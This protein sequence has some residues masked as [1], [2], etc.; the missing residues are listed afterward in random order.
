MATRIQVRRGDASEWTS[1]D[2]VL[3]EGELGY[4]TDTGKFKIGNG[5]DL[6]S[7]LDY[8]L[9]SSDLSG[10]LTSS[11]ASTI[12]LTQ[13]SAS[14]TYL[15]QDSASTT[16]LTQQSA[17]ANYLTQE[18]ASSTYSPIVPTTQTGFRN[19]I[20]NGDFR[21][22][23]RNNGALKNNS[24]PNTALATTF[25]ADRWLVSERN[26][27]TGF[28]QRASDGTGADKYYLSISSPSSLNA[29]IIAQRIEAI[30][31][32][33]LAGKT[34][35]LSF[36][37]AIL[38]GYTSLSWK[39]SYANTTDSF[40]SFSS[41]TTTQIATGN[42]TV[43]SSFNSYSATFTVPSEATTGIEISF[44]NTNISLDATTLRLSNVQLELGSTA[45]PFEQRPIGTELALCQRYFYGPLGT[46]NN[47]P[48][49]TG[50]ATSNST[51]RIVVT[52]PVTLRTT[53][54]FAIAGTTRI[55]YTTLGDMLYSNATL[56]DGSYSPYSASIRFEVS[57]TPLTVGQAVFYV[58]L[59][60]SSP[61]FSAEL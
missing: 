2:P 27:G 20:I 5:T 50:V 16:Y 57:G 3:S 25:G 15:T 22:D 29:L 28:S 1:V 46:A 9:D 32:Y 47:Q 14:T 41:P 17:S 26:T 11:S 44:Y 4:E 10:Y 12:Y 60:N 35:T 8:F 45:T 23:Q 19:R 56:L 61:Q 36:R 18:S 30:N 13:A 55:G 6:W 43:G 53:P 31:S 37:A 33:D 38:G 49:G 58:N 54:T 40:G 24:S 34:V 52:Y 39:A 21:I 59:T 48:V 7:S 42:V 51:A